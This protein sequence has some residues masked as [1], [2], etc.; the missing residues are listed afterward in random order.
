V[1][2]TKRVLLLI[3]AVVALLFPI[4]AAAQKN[5][6]GVLFGGYAALGSS[7]D[8]TPSFALEGVYARQILSLG[9]LGAYLE[10]PVLGTFHTGTQRNIYALGSYS[11]LFVTPGFK[12][13]FAPGYLFSPYLV[14]GGGVAHFSSNVP[15][16]QALSTVGIETSGN[17]AVFDL[18]GGL[19]IKLLPHLILR[20]E[21]RDFH[22][23]TPT[24]LGILGITGHHLV[25]A[26]GLALKF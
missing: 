20:G 23:A 11:A 26:G 9:L 14:A 15:S 22:S 12:V 21:V 2:E 24:V 4:A 8:V 25:G 5:E 7:L 13:K 1:N 17:K 10:L 6:A 18:G 19:D 16:N 3:G